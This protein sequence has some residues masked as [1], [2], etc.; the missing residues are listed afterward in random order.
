[1][2]E[3]EQEEEQEDTYRKAMLI[4]IM[5]VVEEQV[6]FTAQLHTDSLGVLILS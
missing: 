3:K 1:V 2:D 6:G 5:G 4:K